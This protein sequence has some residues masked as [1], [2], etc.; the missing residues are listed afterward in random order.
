MKN[1]LAQKIAIQSS[2]RQTKLSTLC[3]TILSG[4]QDEPTCN[5]PLQDL[6]LDKLLLH[7]TAEGLHDVSF[8]FR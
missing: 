5:R 6:L 1:V 7:A 4:H 8:Y 3:G 2:H